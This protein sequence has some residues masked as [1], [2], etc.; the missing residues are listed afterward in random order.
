MGWST[1]S[2]GFLT[3]VLLKSLK[4]DGQM[5]RVAAEPVKCCRNASQTLRHSNQDGLLWEGAARN[6]CTVDN[7]SG[8]PQQ[9]LDLVIKLTLRITCGSNA[10]GLSN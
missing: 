8:E 9:K 3:C 2:P 7:C 10:F 4:V 5:L 6:V 1:A